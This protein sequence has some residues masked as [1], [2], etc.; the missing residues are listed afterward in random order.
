MKRVITLI[1]EDDKE[2]PRSCPIGPPV[3]KLAPLGVDHQS[4]PPA[5]I[6]RCIIAQLP[7]EIRLTLSQSAGILATLHGTFLET[8]P[9]ARV[10]SPK[11]YYQ[12]ATAFRLGRPL[13]LK[14]HSLANFLYSYRQDFR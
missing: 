11:K 5:D 8:L 13:H 9:K 1:I 4:I 2:E 14:S 6:A 12:L 7:S 10:K 3:E